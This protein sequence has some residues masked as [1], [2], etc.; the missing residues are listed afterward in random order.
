MVELSVGDF[1][2]VMGFEEQGPVQI[3]DIQH[4][5]PIEDGVAIMVSMVCPKCEGHYMGFHPN[6]VKKVLL[7]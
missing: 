7:S 2:T 1:V 6:L 4:G 3:T 5:A